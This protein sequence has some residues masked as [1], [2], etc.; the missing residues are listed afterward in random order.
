MCQRRFLDR[1]K[2]AVLV[3]G[4]GGVSEELCLCDSKGTW[5]YHLRIRVSHQLDLILVLFFF[6]ERCHVA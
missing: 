3:G 4:G 6:F 2:W 1:S 5:G